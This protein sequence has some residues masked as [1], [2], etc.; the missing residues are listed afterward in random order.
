MRCV[1]WSFFFFF[2]RPLTKGCSGRWRIIP[3]KA[4]MR[5]PQGSLLYPMLFSIYVRPFNKII[6]SCDVGCHQ[7]VNDTT[8]NKSPFLSV[9][10]WWLDALTE[11]LRDNQPKLNP[12]A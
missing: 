12:N 7:Y 5:V 8:L 10:A 2:T 4:D 1:W 11:W 3:L 9:L 6:Q